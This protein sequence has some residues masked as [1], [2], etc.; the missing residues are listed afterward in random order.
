MAD[1][2]CNKT[3][4]M[5]GFTRSIARVRD[6]A[7]YIVPTVD[8]G[9]GVSCFEFKLPK[10]LTPNT[11]S[12]KFAEFA[13]SSEI[14]LPSNDHAN[15]GQMNEMYSLTHLG[16]GGYMG[17]YEC[18]SGET[19]AYMLV[20]QSYDMCAASA[21]SEITFNRVRNHVDAAPNLEIRESLL[22]KISKAK[23]FLGYPPYEAAINRSK[24]NRLYLA[25]NFFDA[26]GIQYNSEP[27]NIQGHEDTLAIC[28]E[29]QL[30]G[31][32]LCTYLKREGSFLRL[33]NSA[34][35]Y[36]DLLKGAP[37]HLPMHEGLRTLACPEGHRVEKQNKFMNGVAMGSPYLR[38]NPYLTSY[39]REDASRINKI[40]TWQSE[41]N[42]MY[43][44]DP[45]MRTPTKVALKMFKQAYDIVVMPDRLWRTLGVAVLPPIMEDLTLHELIAYSDAEHIS[46]PIRMYGQI[47]DIW[48]DLQAFM[49]NREAFLRD[50]PPDERGDF[51]A[52]YILPRISD[53]F[54]QEKIGATDCVMEHSVLKQ[55]VD[56]N[57]L[58][59]KT[60]RHYDQHYGN[61]SSQPKLHETIR[62]EA[63][64]IPPSAPIP[65]PSNHAV[66]EDLS[67]LPIGES[68]SE[69]SSGMSEMDVR[70]LRKT[71]RRREMKHSARAHPNI[72]QTGNQPAKT[73]DR[74]TE[75]K[76]KKSVIPIPT[77]YSYGATEDEGVE[78][79][80]YRDLVIAS[81]DDDR[82]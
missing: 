36:E 65:L 43:I 28:S 70:T 21:F 56:N 63:R 26:F 31:D 9:R 37:W 58:I 18:G 66:Y 29:T 5:C 24:K 69:A 81:T 13:R 68:G 4:E 34:Y 12:T 22:N 78:S 6:S 50:I 15:E 52:E 55:M 33:Y 25:A 53:L 45:Q 16:E 74:K 10:G 38:R 17:V 75:K 49:V 20:V 32:Y 82:I 54:M 27:L 30:T 71:S 67:M 11:L 79:D 77:Y 42:T 41:L 48:L 2:R 62:E 23:T 3:A 7:N 40:V 19:N 8:M 76:K 57:D 60:M 80:C 51:P 14:F 39:N 64:R 47:I 44:A 72:S 61:L 73:S 59:I 1:F 35:S 46:I